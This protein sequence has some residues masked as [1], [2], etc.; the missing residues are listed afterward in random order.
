[1]RL[2]LGAFA[3]IDY[4]GLVKERF[5]FV[6]GKWVERH[7]LHLTYLFLGEHPTPY[8]IIEK[9]EGI[10]YE[11]KKIV[12][13]GIGFFG[14]P[15]KVLY[16][17][18]EDETIERLHQEIIARLGIAPDKPFLPHVTLCRIK[19]VPKFSRFIETVRKY[20]HQRL[21]SLTSELVLIESFLTPKGP[22]YRVIHTF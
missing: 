6:Q 12:L 8:P 2:F 11:K 3:T 13:S 18:A 17:K 1:M 4:Y 22:K 14:N 21:G 19:K 20:Q 16:A 7:N 15:P 9:L 5:S 10:Q